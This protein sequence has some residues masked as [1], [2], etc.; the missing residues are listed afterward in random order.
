MR[1]RSASCDNLAHARRQPLAGTTGIGHTRWATHG[2][3]SEENAHPHTDCKG[4][5]AVVHNGIIENYLELRAELA[6]AGH[7]L[8]CET[9]TET[10]AHLIEGVLRGRLV[11]SGRQ[12]RKRSTAATPSPWFTSITPTRSSPRART[13]R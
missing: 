11:C 6:A 2:R 4:R 10:I 3:P 7:M 13:R 5:I 1:R 9:D 8:R 12:G